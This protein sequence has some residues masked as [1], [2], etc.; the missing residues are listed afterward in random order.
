MIKLEKNLSQPSYS[1][2]VAQLLRNRGLVKKEEI[3]AF[4]DPA[5]EANFFDPYL[6]KD[7]ANAVS[8]VIERVKK[9]ELII[10]YG[11]Y[12]ADGVTA[13]ALLK[14][15]LETLRANVEVYI[16][17][18]VSEGYGLNKEALATIAQLGAK[19]VITVDNGIR[20]KAEVDYAKS[21]GL[22]IVITDHHRPPDAKKDFP[23]CLIIDP[24]V[25]G[26]KYPF[27]DLSG[28]GVAFKLAV[29]LIGRSTLTAE[30]K[31]VLQDRLLDVAAI[32]TVADCVPL[33]GENRALVKR[34]LEI[35]NETK[36]VG[37]IELMKTVQLKTN[38]RLDAWNIAFQ[39]APRLNAAGRLEH[40][41]TAFELL[42]TKNR[43]EA[44]EIARRLNARNAERQG[45]TDEIVAA[46]EKGIDPSAEIIISVYDKDKGTDIWNEGVIG[47][48]AGRICEKF[49]RP[50]V[51]ITKS[52]DEYKGSGRSIEDFD[53]IAAVS[54]CQEYLARFGGHPGAC[55]FSLAENNLAAFKKQLNRIAD[56]EL[57]KADLKPKIMIDA[58]MRPEEI[59]EKM[60]LEVGLFAPFGAGNERPKFLS[61]S[62]KITDI[63]NM[64]A[65]GQH[66][67]LKLNNV[68]TSAL[69]AIGFG[70]SEKWQDLRAGDII[71]IVYFVEMNEFNGRR[72]VQLKIID[73]KVI[74]AKSI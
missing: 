3:E 61:R 50:A 18:R 20:N 51:V 14:E 48:V 62:I 74:E 28:A 68:Y 15:T 49:Y 64:G 22:E 42:A 33:L 2:L 44:V 13:S 53:L 12:D 8:A 73:I 38:C 21:L 58:E 59:N 40:A 45:I 26:E 19:M 69:F 25:R 11:D 10:V 39:I 1:W 30:Q 65:D 63:M 6:F 37:L 66:I 16:P 67:K 23:E 36:R 55:G 24:H 31:K 9:Q 4:L 71:D 47:L 57:G 52:G 27:K 34:G 46:V 54:E 70:Q 29:A 7:M 17:D 41:N 5:R 35:L 60:I 56:R 72:E 43:S 32:G